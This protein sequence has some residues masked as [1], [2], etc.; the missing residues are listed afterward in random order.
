MYLIFF[1]SFCFY[2]TSPE[3]NLH[4]NMPK[5]KTKSRSRARGPGVDVLG[6]SEAVRQKRNTPSCEAST[7]SEQVLQTGSYR[8]P[9]VVASANEIEPTGS[10]KG[11]VEIVS[12]PIPVVCVCMIS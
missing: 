1:F 12:G 9:P 5:A 8:L 3:R 2:T 10:T 7:G 6:L 11:Y 4:S